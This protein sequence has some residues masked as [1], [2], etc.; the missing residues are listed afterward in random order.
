MFESTLRWL[1]LIGIIMIPTFI[2]AL[3]WMRRMVAQ[4]RARLEEDLRNLT[5]QD[6]EKRRA[7]RVPPQASGALKRVTE[8]IEKSVKTRKRVARVQLRKDIKLL[9]VAPD[10]LALSAAGVTLHKSFERVKIKSVKKTKRG[11]EI[12]LIGT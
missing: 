8:S 10:V 12:Q 5:S 9:R 3:F 11:Y 1:I 7:K 4:K 6:P 2:F